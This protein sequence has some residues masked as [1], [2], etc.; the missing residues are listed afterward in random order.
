MDEAAMA[1]RCPRSAVLGPAML[2]RHRLVIMREGYASVVRDP[3]HAVYG[4]LWDVA[5][6]DVRVLDKYESLDRGLYSKVSQPVKRLDGEGVS[7]LQQAL[8]YLGRSEGGGVPV[9]GYLEN[10]IA[11]V[12]KFNFPPAYLAHVKSL[13]NGGGG[14]GSIGARGKTQPAVSKAKAPTRALRDEKGDII[15]RKRFGSPTDSRG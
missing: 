14:T 12:E 11:C 9:Q 8:V 1:S 13:G 15:V 10:V 6:S 3:R 5:L 4:L 7:P 2:H